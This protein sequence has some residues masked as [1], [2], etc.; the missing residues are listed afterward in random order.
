MIRPE[1]KTTKFF[2]IHRVRPGLGL[3]RQRLEQLAANK[4]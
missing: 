1:R 2:V 3:G 4:P